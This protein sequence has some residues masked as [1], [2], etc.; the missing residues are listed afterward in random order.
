MKTLKEIKRYL[1]EQETKTLTSKRGNTY[2]VIELDKEIIKQVKSF[3]TLTTSYHYVN[4]KKLINI[5]WV[6]NGKIT[7]VY[8][9]EK[10]E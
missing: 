3:K 7:N 1:K 4:G 10:E 6:E 5:A 2:E 8:A 9:I